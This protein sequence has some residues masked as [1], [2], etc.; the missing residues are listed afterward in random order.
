[1]TYQTS[2]YVLNYSVKISSE[3]SPLHPVSTK[4]RYNNT[5]RK[6]I[7]STYHT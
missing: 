7:D 2:F 5:D 3:M 1:M 4:N 6:L